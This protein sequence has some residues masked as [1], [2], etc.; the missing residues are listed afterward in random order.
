MGLIAEDVIQQV[1][2]RS[3]IVDIVGEYVSLKKSG[4]NFKG[5]SPFTDEKTPSFIVSPDKQIFHC[6]STGVGGNVISFLMKIDHLSFPEAVRVLAQK[7]NVVIPESVRQANQQDDHSQIYDVNRLAAEF[8]HDRLLKDSQPKAAAARDYLIS[9]GFDLETVKTFQLGYSPDDWES[10]LKHLQTRNISLALMEKAGL[11]ISRENKQGYYDRFRNRV[12]FPIF[13]TQGR[14]RAFGARTMEPKDSAKYINSPETRV[15]VKGQHLYGFHLAKHAVTKED[16][17]IVVEGYVDCIMPVQSGVLNVV[18]SLGTALTVEQIRLLRRYS[19][20]I[21]L[22]FDSDRAGEAAMLRSFD[23]LLEEDMQV[24]VASLSP[25]EDPDSFIRKFGV[26][27]FR[28]RIQNASSL[29][30]FK[31]DRL[32]AKYD[33]KSVD[34]R[35]RI[36]SEMLPTV[37]KFSSAVAQSAYIRQL[38]YRLNVPEAALLAE[39]KKNEGTPK[40]SS[41]TSGVVSAA[42]EVGKNVKLSQI[43]AVECSLLKLVLE[44]DQ[45]VKNMRSE[46]EVTDFQDHSIRTV[47][48]KIYHLFDH[49]QKITY[50]NLLEVL[51]E[52]ATRN[53][54][55]RLVTEESII[56]ENKE[57]MHRDCIQRIRQDRLRSQRQKLLQ[58]IR[59][60]E[61]QKDE[62]RLDLLKAKFNELIKQVG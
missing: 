18:A 8:F 53:F 25:G 41:K 47:M 62:P 7:V 16:F 15:Y 42:P 5:L 33:V 11:I 38:A 40:N 36:A 34:H 58:E 31:L 51:P 10:L 22:L 1:L 48:E 30:D 57:K 43:R 13:D 14:C 12:M 24:K 56:I 4:R 26:D 21:C 44:E 52:E 59:E 35:T 45:F 3:D 28:Q 29:F 6:F 23:L 39:I 49:G 61:G 17:A 50:H 27:E 19:K 46:V 60:A 55:T 2:D 32:M 54:V 20:N 9:R 37:Q